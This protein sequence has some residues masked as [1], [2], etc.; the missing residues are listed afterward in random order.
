MDVSVVVCTYNRADT[1]VHCLGT[2][3]EQE[4]P[5]D[6]KWEVVVVDNNSTDGTRAAVERFLAEG[7]HNFRYLFEG[8]QGK[9]HALNTGV[10]CT[11]GR[12]IAFLDDDV[13]VDR[14]WL[15]NVIRIF[16]QYRCAGM[17]GRI[18]AD[19]K[20][21][22]PS[23]L[24]LSDEN[25]FRGI[26]PDFDFGTEP[27][28]LPYPEAPFGANAAFTR[29]AFEKYGGYRTELGPPTVPGVVAGEDTEFGQRLL[30]AGEVIMYAPDAVVRHPVDEGRLR[31]A[32]FRRWYFNCGRGAL[33]IEKVP[34]GAAH[35]FG[36]PRYLYRELAGSVLKLLR[37][38][39]RGRPFYDELLIWYHAG[40]MVEA[41]SM[42][43][44]GE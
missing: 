42:F 1:V 6:L 36:V 7:P 30:K 40:R 13:T 31:K 26:I 24:R 21:E 35:Y 17:G 43:H 4:V 29:E 11:S 23:W 41:R 8:R 3:R 28:P 9:S 10:R 32:F 14:R 19:W 34:N 5:P 18:I 27:C 22:P 15:A 39:Y 33:R 20:C 37:N 25:Q 44:R 16:E 2:L 38:L 12:I